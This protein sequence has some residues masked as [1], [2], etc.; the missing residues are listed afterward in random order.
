MHS[1]IFQSSISFD[2]WFVVQGL[3]HTEGRMVSQE[4]MG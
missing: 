4:V 3:G 1:P 2:Q